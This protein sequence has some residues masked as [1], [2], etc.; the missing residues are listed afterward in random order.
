MTRVAVIGASG[1][2]GRVVARQALAQGL[3][4]TALVRS[5]ERL[6]AALGADLPD[7]L[8]VTRCDVEAASVADLA[9]WLAGHDAVINTA[10]HVTQGEAFV[11]LVGRL[12]QALE[13]L[14]A[15]GRPVAWFLAG[16]AALDIG[17]RDLRGV[18]LPVIRK[19]YWPHERNWRRLESSSLDWRLLC[20][21]PMTDSPPLGSQALRVSLDRSP[22]EPPP[23]MRLL[24]AVALLPW[25]ARGMPQLIVSYEDAAA[26]MLAHLA[27]GDAFARH[28]VGLALPVGMKGHKD[29]W[30]ARPAG[31]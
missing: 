15:E 6:R 2:L 19:T 23:W 29:Q 16:A 13:S 7:G 25:L 31:R 30:T 21:G 18:D 17:S 14:P 9:G 1:Q 24:P 8:Q 5:P 22:L 11:A 27:R 26:L 4:V 10:G 12:V 3:R 28:R 20:P